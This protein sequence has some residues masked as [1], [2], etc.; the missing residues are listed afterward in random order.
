MKP[1]FRS[2]LPIGILFFPSLQS[3]IADESRRMA[4][5]ASYSHELEITVGQRVYSILYRNKI[6]CAIGTGRGVRTDTIWVP[7]NQAAEAR[8]IL[9]Q[10]IKAEN[11]KLTLLVRK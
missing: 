5:V 4:H 8:Q 2:I 6:E 7:A 11:L 3:S 1:N 9:A 10:A